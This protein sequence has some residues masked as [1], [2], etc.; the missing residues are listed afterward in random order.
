[1]YSRLTIEP[2]IYVET[3]TTHLIVRIIISVYV[4]DIIFKK[5]S[6]GIKNYF[7]ST[8]NQLD[9]I[10]TVALGITSS[11]DYVINKAGTTNNE[12]VSNLDVAIR[13][14]LMCRLL[15]YPRNLQYMFPSSGFYKIGRVIRRIGIKIYSLSVLFVCISFMFCSCGVFFFGGTMSKLPLGWDKYHATSLTEYGKNNFYDLNFN[16]FPSA[17]VTLLCCAHVSDFD[18]ITDGFVASTSSKYTRVYFTLWYIIAVLL[19]I[20]ILKSF[21]L[22]EFLVISVTKIQSDDIKQDH[23]NDR[24][25]NINSSFN[26]NNRSNQSISGLPIPTTSNKSIGRSLSKNS[27]ETVTRSVSSTNLIVNEDEEKTKKGPSGIEQSRFTFVLDSKNFIKPMDNHYDSDSEDD[28]TDDQIDND[29]YYLEDSDSNG[30]NSQQS[31]DKIETFRITESSSSAIPISS[32]NISSIPNINPNPLMP[33]LQGSRNINPNPNNPKQGS[34]NPSPNPT[35]SCQGNIT[36][37]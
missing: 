24:N 3:I 19:L 23:I 16:D 17:L 33:R 31:E 20:N 14:I 32:S 6:Y 26:S 22:S 37:L 21:F 18:V 28:Y 4:L 5:L 25:N 35:N 1:M 30:T 15:L 29:V 2:S 7:N 27:L 34:R 36:I 10:I 13:T 9:F 11:L 12:S 8:R